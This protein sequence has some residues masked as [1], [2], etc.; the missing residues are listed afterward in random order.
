M[1]CLCSSSSG[2]QAAEF[3]AMAP[4]MFGVRC[5]EFKRRAPEVR[6]GFGPLR[7]NV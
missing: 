7:F 5:S 1:C 4:A 2:K 3:V 6:R